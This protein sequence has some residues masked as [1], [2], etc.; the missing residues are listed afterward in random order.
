[1]IEQRFSLPLPEPW[2]NEEFET[3]TVGPINYLVGPNGSGKSRFAEHIVNNLSSTRGSTRFLGTDRLSALAAPGALG[4]YYGDPLQSGYP[5]DRFSVYREAGKTG[6]G[7]DTIVLLQERPD[8]RILLEATLSSLFDRLIT[9]EWDSGNLIPTARLGHSGSSYRLDREECHGLRELLVLLTHLYDTSTDYLVIDEPELNLHPQ[10]QSF[11]MSEVRRV[12]G[13]P[14]LDNEKKVVFLVTHSPFI[15]DFKHIDELESIISF[16]LEYKPPKRV[17]NSLSSEKNT[18][19]FLSRLNAENRQLFFSDHP[20]FVEG[21][22][23]AQI[24]SALVEA[25]G[26]SLAGAGSCMIRSEGSEE[27]TWYYRLCRAL[28]KDAY[29]IYDLDSLFHRRLRASLGGDEA[30][31]GLLAEAGLGSDFATYCRDFDRVLL[32]A[33]DHI[34]GKTPPP[35]LTAFQGHLAGLGERAAWS[36]EAKAK[37]RAALL[38]ATYH[39]REAVVEAVSENQVL[40]IEGRLSKI[41][42]ILAEK[43]IFVLPGGSLENHL[44]QYS[45][46]IYELDDRSKRS[47][48]QEALSDI[49]AIDST[50][51]IRER[52][53]ELYDIVE[54]L[55]SRSSIDIAPTLKEHLGRY[56]Y[57]LQNTFVNDPDHT[58]QGIEA[59]LAAKVSDLAGIFSLE[60]F[61]RTGE[62]RF[63]ATVCVKG[64]LDYPDQTIEITDRTNAGML[65]F[66]LG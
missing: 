24:F 17:G 12:A 23:D 43:N 38:V 20:V 7:V 37:A 61:E 51:S 1:M 11:F 5:K 3:D 45:G 60:V 44:P 47:A 30:I 54:Q 19:L 50:S 48:L 6:S 21:N 27:V 53:G 13:D 39:H 15:L 9:L 63:N 10:Y 2:K 62:A 55:P 65:E 57:A 46:N 18:S 40:D 59:A 16:T 58:L 8:L 49:I 32:K 56:V 36:N 52:Y 35:V 22:S 64:L 31:Q 28:Q 25:T 14:S 41:R 26:S 33:V 34:L 66:D 29:F 4:A 42:S